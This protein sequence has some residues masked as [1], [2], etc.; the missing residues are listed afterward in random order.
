MFN[1]FLLFSQVIHFKNGQKLK[2]KLEGLKN[3]LSYSIFFENVTKIHVKR[4]EIRYIF[5]KTTVL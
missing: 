2:L 3:W 1:D 5:T 4:L